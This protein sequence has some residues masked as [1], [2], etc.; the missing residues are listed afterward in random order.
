MYYKINPKIAL[1]SW[2]YVP[3]AYYVE[4]ERNAKKLSK[5]QFLLLN[6]CDGMTPLPLTDT[7]QEL[8]NTGLALPVKKGDVPDDWSI[9][10]QSCTR[11]FNSIY[12]VITGKCNFNCLHCFMAADNSHLMTEL[13]YDDC[14]R[15]L[16]EC[17]ECG[18]QTVVITG[19]EPFLHPRFMDILTACQQRHLTVQDINTNASFLNKKILQD[20]LNLGIAPRLKIS[21][22]C[23]SHHD[24]MRNMP[25]IEQK[26][27][28]AIRLCHDMGF[29]VEVQTN[30]NRENLDTLFETA[31]FF[32]QM[33]IEEMRIIRTTEAP[34]WVDNANGRCL[35]LEEYYDEMT[36]FAA[37]Y[38]AAPRNM[39]IDIWQFLTLSPK[40]KTY[41]YRPIS[42]SG[43][44]YRDNYPVCAGNRGMVSITSS[45]EV[46][47]CAQM[48]GY[49][50]KNGMSLGN[51]HQCSLT[52]LLTD[53]KYLE[54]VTCPICA[55]KEHDSQCTSC[56]YWKLCAGGCR[57]IAL[58]LTHDELARDPAKC[59][60]FHNDWMT[61]IDQ[62]LLS[63][64]SEFHNNNLING[65]P[66]RDSIMTE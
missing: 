36:K 14:I 19:G 52:E 53:S 34:R 61:K 31:D 63:V 1:R 45:G 20:I 21:F 64:N 17:V 13:S 59:I 57:A 18:I 39:S 22:D 49:Y 35:E 40:T 56:K 29:H 30:V 60:F 28:D 7:L 23:I 33:G 16:D 44:N 8:V 55:V 15:I 26:T 9:C 6:Q 62:A 66:V 48:S 43:H 58:A 2:R 41:S 24:W 4:G 65:K 46:V 25:G 27:I 11:Y 5:E 12:L 50:E 47:P 37:A 51:I 42:L 32:D 38:I 54:K 10:H 3:Y